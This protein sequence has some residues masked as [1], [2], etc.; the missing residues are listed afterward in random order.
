ML[1]TFETVLDR[2]GVHGGPESPLGRGLNPESKESEDGH[3]GGWVPPVGDKAGVPVWVAEVA[4]IHVLTS[5][6]DIREF[7]NN[8]AGSLLEV[9]EEALESGDVTDAGSG[10]EETNTNLVVGN[11]I[12]KYPSI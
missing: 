4:A 1:S 9:V 5:F 3:E 8:V 7:L 2:W 10:G 6:K 12:I 11:G